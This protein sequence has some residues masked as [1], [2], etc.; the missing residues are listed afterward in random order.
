MVQ[1]NNLINFYP[2][3]LKNNCWSYIQERCAQIYGQHFNYNKNVLYFFNTK[4]RLKN[5]IIII[6]GYQKESLPSTY[7]GSS[8][9]TKKLSHNYSFGIVERIQK[10]LMGWKGKLFSQVGKYQLLKASLQNIPNFYLSLF[11]N[12]VLI[13]KNIE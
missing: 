7:L 12:L 13:T 8:M 3:K 2:P 10:N 5:K 6:L 11:K 1:F 9:T 4:E